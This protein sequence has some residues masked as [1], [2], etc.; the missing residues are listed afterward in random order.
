MKHRQRTALTHER[1]HRFSTGGGP[2][3]NDADINPEVAVVAPN[4]LVEVPNAVDSDSQFVLGELK[5]YQLMIFINI[6][7]SGFK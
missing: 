7:I 5:H 4:L 3:I 2:P 1:Q 6:G